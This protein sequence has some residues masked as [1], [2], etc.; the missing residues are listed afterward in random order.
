MIDRGTDHRQA[1]RQ[2][3]A[4]TEAR[5]LEHR[6]ALVVIHRQH[7]VGAGQNAGSE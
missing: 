3:D 5:E 7:R 2:I 4:V 6:Q 1:Q